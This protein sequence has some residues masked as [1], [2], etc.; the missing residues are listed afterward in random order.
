MAF[1]IKHF[2]QLEN[3]VAKLDETERRVM[4]YRFGL[5]GRETATLEEVG[6]L[7]GVSRQRVSQIQ[8]EALRHLRKMYAMNEGA[9]V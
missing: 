2:A 7:M 5:N 1:S 4:E 6:E 8:I 9:G 3:T